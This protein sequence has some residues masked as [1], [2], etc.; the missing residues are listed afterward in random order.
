[1]TITAHN[2][3]GKGCEAA[4]REFSSGEVIEARPTKEY[5]QREE[6]E[7]HLKQGR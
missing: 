1:M 4:V 7:Q 6:Q 2:F 3:Q 5:Y